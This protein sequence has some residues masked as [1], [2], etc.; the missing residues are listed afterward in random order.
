MVH[1][2]AVANQTGQR[3][4]ECGREPEAADVLGDRRLLIL[5]TDVDT[6]QRLRPFQRGRL[7][8]MNDVDR[9]LFGLQ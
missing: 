9:R 4:A 7:G 8:E 1:A 5:G 6:H 2:D 3:R